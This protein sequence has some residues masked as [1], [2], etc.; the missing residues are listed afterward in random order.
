MP[1]P[2][3][4][5]SVPPSAQCTPPE[6][7]P[8][9]SPTSA[10][11]TN[12]LVVASLPPPF[13]DALVLNALRDH[14]TSFGQLHT[15]A[16]LR[17]FARILLV[18]YSEHD[19]EI[20]KQSCDS[21]VVGPLPG[22]AEVTIRVYR[23]DPTPVS[24]GGSNYLRP[25]EIEKNFLISPPGSPPVGWEPIREEPPNGTPLAADLAVALRKLQLQRESKHGIEVLIEPDD[26][27]GIGIYVEDCDAMEETEPSEDDWVYGEPPPSRLQYKPI[28]TALPPMAV[29]A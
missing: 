9:S 5:L 27:P 12:T 20:A 16:P 2:E 1:V 23:A 13:F 18:Y 17:S 24:P 15:W 4:S 7:S 21:L 26:G 8:S 19:A 10:N 28:P 11:R 6:L 25:P 14:F 29:G 3:L 22:I